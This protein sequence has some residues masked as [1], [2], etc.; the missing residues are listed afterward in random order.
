[1]YDNYNLRKNYN[2]LSEKLTFISKSI[3]KTLYEIDSINKKFDN[4]YK[5]DGNARKGLLKVENE[6]SILDKRINKVLLLEVDKQI[7]LMNR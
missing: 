7:Q 4:G 5:I 3:K 1:M 6:L 2:V